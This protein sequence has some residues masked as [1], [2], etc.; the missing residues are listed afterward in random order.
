MED[1]LTFRN[2]LWS[3]TLALEIALLV[4]MRFH[5]NHRVLPLFYLYLS[6]AVAQTFLLLFLYRVRSITSLTTW[7]LAWLTQVPVLCT[8]GLVI[9]EIC[10]RHLRRFSGVWA[11]AWRLLVLSGVA[12]FVVSLLLSKRSWTLAVLAADRGI[13]LAIAVILVVL[14]AFGMHYE[15]TIE[16]V[17]RSLSIGFLLYS[18]FWVIN[19][20]IL[21]HWLHRYSDQWAVLGM[22]AFLA[23]LLVWAGALRRPIPAVAPQES[24][25]PE[26]IYRDVSP[27]I[28]LQLRELNARLDRAFDR[29]ARP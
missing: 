22:L 16:P 21:E 12:V 3:V 2:L 23:S 10:R 28:N 6:V 26:G 25:L 24:L 1:L 13:E 19:N 4:W 9:V 15:V 29:Q 8:R 18:C 11:L 7:R 17:V 14:F 20:S 27:E 5:N